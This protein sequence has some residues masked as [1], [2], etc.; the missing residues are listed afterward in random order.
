MCNT[1]YGR[2]GCPVCQE[3]ERGIMVTCQD[4]DGEGILTYFG[5]F[6][7][8]ISQEQYRAL[9]VQKRDEEDCPSCEGEGWT[10]Y[11]YEPDEGD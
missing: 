5:E 6:G 7:E 4:C 10:I 1:C 2:T 11:E 3:E 8:E 9:P